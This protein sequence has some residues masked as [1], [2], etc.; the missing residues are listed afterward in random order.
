[1]GHIIVRTSHHTL[2]APSAVG[3]TDPAGLVILIDRSREA[4]ETLAARTGKGYC[5]RPL[6]QRSQR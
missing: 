6:T 3:E 5:R 2:P 4:A 1:M